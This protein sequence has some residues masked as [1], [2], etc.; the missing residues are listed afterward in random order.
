MQDPR[1]LGH[2]VDR[3]VDR[4]AEDVAPQCHHQIVVGQDVPYLLRLFIEEF[5]RREGL[6]PPTVESEALGLLLSYD[7][8]GNVREL[9]NLMEGAVA[10]ADGTVDADLL[11]S[12]LGAADDD[13]PDA[14]D[15]DTIEKRHIERVLKLTEGNKSAAAKMLGVDRRTL[16][17]KGF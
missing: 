6:E 3:R 15:L 13:T 2:G 9:Q 4:H 7:W 14:L 5:C 1:V 12:L 11:R 16:Q 10:L 17:R 8:P